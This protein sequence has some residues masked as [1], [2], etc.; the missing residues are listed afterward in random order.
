MIKVLLL[1]SENTS[2]KITSAFNGSQIEMVKVINIQAV[3]KTLEISKIDTL[4]IE[5]EFCKTLLLSH[6]Y[7]YELLQLTI[8]VRLFVLKHEV[9]SD[10][11][12]L[13][14]ICEKV[15]DYCIQK[16]ITSIEFN[17]DVEDWGVLRERIINQFPGFLNRLQ[18]QYPTLSIMNIRLCIYLKQGFTNKEISKKMS[19]QPDSIKKSITRIKKKMNLERKDNI[20]NF[21]LEL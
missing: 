2:D 14:S 6:H 8:N 10:D 1:A 19:V 20:R 9:V 5:D 18:K 15:I 17:L 3:I 7:F 13:N 4:I 16:E 21:L 12:E 11:K